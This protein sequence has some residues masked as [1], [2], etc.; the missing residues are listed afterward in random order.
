MAAA[1]RAGEILRR[2]WGRTHNVEKKGAI[3]LVTEADL[4]SEDA[5]VGLIRTSFPDHAVLA[6]EGGATPGKDR[7]E[8][9]VDPL[10]GTTNY[11]HHLP[12]FS[13]SIAFALEGDIVFGLILSPVTGELF[14][15]TRGQGATL[16]GRPIHVSGTKRVGESLLVTGFPYDLQ[17]VIRPMMSRME[18]CILAAQG[19]RRLCNP[20]NTV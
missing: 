11:A 18:R 1:A 16:N 5:I 14:S 20:C 17:P 3:D 7:C 19:V 2:Y 15:G 8:W 10:D 6:E 13:V 4:A 12:E 9:I